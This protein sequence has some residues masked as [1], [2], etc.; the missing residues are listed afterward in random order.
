MSA[1]EET[2]RAAGPRRSEGRRI[3]LT[4]GAVAGLQFAYHGAGVLGAPG[5]QAMRVLGLALSGLLVWVVL[6]RPVPLG[7]P[8]EPRPWAWATYGASLVLM[9]AA[10]PAAAALLRL[11]DLSAAM[12]SV[13]A[14][15]VGLHF[16]PF[17]RAFR[18]RFFVLLGGVLALTGAVGVVA[19]VRLP[20]AGSIAAGLAGLVMLGLQLGWVWDRWRAVTR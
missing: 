10:F 6:V 2:V 14:A 20:D 12:P 4:V 16:L 13:A 18:E 3:G 5:D 19:A 11:L 7:V 9:V 17:S 8:P 15:L 1:A